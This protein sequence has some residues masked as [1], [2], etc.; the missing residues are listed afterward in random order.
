M[1]LLPSS[2]LIVSFPASPN[3]LIS[4]PSWPSRR[5]NS[6][7]VVSAA[8]RDVDSFTSKSG[9]LF[10]LSADEADSLSEYNFSRIDGMYK[11]K[12]LILL[13]RLAQIGTTFGYW[14]GLR[15]ADEA[16]ERSEQMF[17]VFLQFRDLLFI[18]ALNND[19]FVLISRFRFYELV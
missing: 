11:K 14:F 17:K 4:S 12:P 1:I 3:L 19:D 15:L 16:L 10:S 2:P 9:Y 6:N 5:G 7:V 13:R 8:S 18:D